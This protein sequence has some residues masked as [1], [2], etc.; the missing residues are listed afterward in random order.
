[1]KRWGWLGFLLF[2][3]FLSGCL[4]AYMGR[5]YSMRGSVY[6]V[7]ISSTTLQGKSGQV[8]T[9]EVLLLPIPP[10]KISTE[11][12]HVLVHFKNKNVEILQPRITKETH[13]GMTAK[14]WTIR[15][16]FRLQQE[17]TWTVKGRFHF[18]VCSK[19]A[20]YPRTVSLLWKLKAS[21]ADSTPIPPRLRPTPPQAH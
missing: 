9:G 8:V 6:Q 13:K 5:L 19:T 14:R 11:Y 15:P 17:G 21:K 3:G 2:A 18:G 4:P 10:Y 1:M 12:P 20:C 7:Q 16:R